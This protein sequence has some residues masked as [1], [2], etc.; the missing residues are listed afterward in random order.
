VSRAGSSKN[1]G[2]QWQLPRVAI[3]LGANAAGVAFCAEVDSWVAELTWRV[4]TD[5]PISQ[6][7]GP[8]MHVSHQPEPI[9]RWQF[10]VGL[11]T[12]LVYAVW[13]LSAELSTART[14]GEELKVEVA[15]VRADLSHVRDLCCTHRAADSTSG[16][17]HE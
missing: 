13:H 6:T 4:F 2:S 3:G 17:T 5:V 14:T 15:Q 12:T 10:I 7:R 9:A 16:S 8:T 1:P 11:L